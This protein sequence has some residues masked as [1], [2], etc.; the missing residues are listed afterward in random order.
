[1]KGN[2]MKHLKYI[3]IAMMASYN[4]LAHP[5]TPNIEDGGNL[6][7]I[8]GYYDNSSDHTQTAMQHICFSPYSVNGTQIWGS[9]YS[10]S[11]AGWDGRY[12]Q[13]GDQL[14]L[15]GDF[16]SD[17]GHDGMELNIV[18]SSP[19]NIAT[20]HWREWFED[21]AYGSSQVF[22]NAKMKRIGS[23]TLTGESPLAV[24]V[25]LRSDGTPAHSPMDPGQVPLKTN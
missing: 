2:I 17:T 3:L 6:W 11:Y 9:W 21:G 7:E 8:T 20:G 23:C 1:M 13:E 12:A 10:T 5:P 24:P 22:V 16:S 15:F 18:G 19:D 4:V 14:F 25:R